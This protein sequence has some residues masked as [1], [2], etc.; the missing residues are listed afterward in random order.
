[1]SG[2]DEAA[3]DLNKRFGK[4]TVI[5]GDEFKGLDIPRISTGSLTLDIATGGGLPTGR[6]IEIFGMESSGK[7]YLALKTVGNAQKM[8]KKAVW[9]DVEGV[10]DAEWATLLGVDISKLF[11]VRPESGEQAG[12]ALE[13]FVRAEDCGIIVLDSIAA[14]IPEKD[15]ETSMD[16][17]EKLGNKA[18]MVNRL[19]RKLQSALNMKVGDDRVPNEC[20]VIFINQIRHKIGVMYGSPETTPGGLGLRFASS[21]RIHLRKK[22]IKDEKDAE[23]IIGQTVTF[24]TEKNKTFPPHRVGQF[25]LYTDGEQKGQIDLPREVLNCALECDLIEL[26]GKTYHIDGENIGVGKP[27]AADYLTDNPEKVEKL[28]TRIMEH[29]FGKK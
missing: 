13:T 6:L 24:K 17:P 3:A 27:K 8:G 16:A 25:D 26:S 20:M 7:T 21:V 14:L 29:Y 19:L 2:L 15:I 4:N 11:V 1:M 9:I 12:D 23:K 5:S 28:K 10:F 22:W 18:V